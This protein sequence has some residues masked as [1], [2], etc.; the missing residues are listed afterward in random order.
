M[1][2]D[3]DRLMMIFALSLEDQARDCYL[4]LPPAC[5]Q[6]SDEFEDLFMKRWSCNVQG[7]FNIKKFYQITK[8]REDFREFIQKFDRVVKDIP[9]H[10]KPKSLINS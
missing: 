10:L 7:T 9:N 3:E 8:G 6:D 2:F 1:I 4:S 5:I